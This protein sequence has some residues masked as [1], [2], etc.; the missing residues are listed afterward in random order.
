LARNFVRATPTVIAR[1][2]SASTARRKPAAIS[3]GGPAMRRRP[4]TSR[5]ASSIDSP[6][7]RGVVRSNTSKTAFDA[8]V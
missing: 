2:T 5:N 1:P 6:S 8:S 4:A 7:T 3:T